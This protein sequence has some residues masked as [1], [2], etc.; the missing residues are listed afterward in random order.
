MFPLIIEFVVYINILCVV[1]VSFFL[2][3]SKKDEPKEYPE[4]FKKV[5]ILKS[6]KEF[7]K[8]DYDRL[9]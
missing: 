5:Y 8:K 7:E 3:L 2:I 4:S 1:L 9:I 6:N